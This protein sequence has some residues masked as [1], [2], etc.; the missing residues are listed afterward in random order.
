MSSNYSCPVKAAL[1]TESTKVEVNDATVS[2]NDADGT[3]ITA[4]ELSAIGGT[5]T[6]TV[7][8]TNAIDI[9]VARTYCSFN[10]R[11]G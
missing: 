11:F 7:T 2:V 5:T 9:K 6:G 3:A 10:Y 4:K 1:V 8:V